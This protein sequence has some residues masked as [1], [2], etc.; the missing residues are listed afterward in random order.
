[1]KNLRVSFTTLLSILIMLFIFDNCTYKYKLTIINTTNDTLKVAFGPYNPPQSFSFTD[2][3]L[4]TFLPNDTVKIRTSAFRFVDVAF[5]CEL[6]PVF[7]MN[8][9]GDTISIN[10]FTT[11][12]LF[13]ADKHLLLPISK[14]DT[15]LG[16]NY[17][18][19]LKK[20]KQKLPQFIKAQYFYNSAKY[21]KCLELLSNF[22]SDEFSENILNQELKSEARIAEAHYR[23][24]LIMG[25]L[26]AAKLS[27]FDKSEYYFN[28]LE[29]IFPEYSKFVF[30]ND[31]ELK[32][33]KNKIFK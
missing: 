24:I 12:F 29:L 4:Y 18:K 2:S 15:T 21:N 5:D 10:R 33:Y 9:N 1:M 17:L 6:R 30:K 26:S 31:P 19:N 23:G 22:K 28:K 8:M 11:E 14:M 13:S 16:K 27:I 20:E 3:L 25:F 7:T 32:R